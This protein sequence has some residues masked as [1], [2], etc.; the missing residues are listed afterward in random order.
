MNLLLG[1]TFDNRMLDFFE[2]EVT[3]YLPISYFSGITIDSIMKPVVIFQG[4]VFDTDFELVRVKKFFMDFCILYD[5]DCVNVSDLKRICVISAGDDKVIKM[6]SYQIDKIDPYIVIDI[7]KI[8][9]GK[10]RT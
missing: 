5:I 6:R 10:K 4:D 3:N 2:F 1:S 8:Y 7:F 9:L